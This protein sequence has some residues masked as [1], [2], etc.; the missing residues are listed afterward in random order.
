M[1]PT[2]GS[3]ARIEGPRKKRARRIGRVLFIIYMAVLVYF[4]FFADWYDHAPGAQWEY[5]YN[6]VPFREI[7]RYIIKARKIGAAAVLLNLAGNVAGF[8]PFGFFLPVMSPALRGLLKVT[9]LGFFVSLEVEIVQLLTRS[10]RCDV[11]DI[12]LN[13]VGA[14]AG[15]LLFLLVNR[16]RKEVQRRYGR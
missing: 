10:G 15:Y 3:M 9:G 4:L 13:T 8:M 16:W 6:I 5:H 2:T 14:A 11:D 1:T 7:L 12:I